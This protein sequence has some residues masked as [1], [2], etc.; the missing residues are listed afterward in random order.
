M[1]HSVDKC[2]VLRMD[3]YAVEAACEQ[4]GDQPDIKAFLLWGAKT[5]F[6]TCCLS[7]SHLEERLADW[8]GS[9]DVLM[10]PHKYG[11]RTAGDLLPHLESALDHL[12]PTSYLDGLYYLLDEFHTKCFYHPFT[13]IDYN[14]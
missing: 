8:T 14:P 10:D 7:R 6:G 1:Y 5:T 12:R 3:R 13:F 9:V 4:V 11:L 2:Y